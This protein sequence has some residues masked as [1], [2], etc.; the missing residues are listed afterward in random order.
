[1]PAPM[2]SFLADMLRTHSSKSIDLVC[3]NARARSIPF[4]CSTNA[5]I[6][7]DGF[8]ATRLTPSLSDSANSSCITIDE[9]KPSPEE[10]L[11][12]PTPPGNSDPLTPRDDSTPSRGLKSCTYLNS[13]NLFCPG[14]SQYLFEV[15]C[16]QVSQSASLPEVCLDQTN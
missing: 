5:S 15:D 9:N 3:D 8:I 7:E 11:K 4:D 10:T 1:M 16:R 12:S 6:C 2:N 13:M 14:G